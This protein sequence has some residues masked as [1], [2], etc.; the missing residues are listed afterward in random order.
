MDR[1]EQ[2]RVFVAVA[3]LRSFSR[4]AKQLER[5]PQAVTRAVAA[6]EQRL[7]TPL[8]HRTTRSVSLTSDGERYLEK[9]RRALAEMEALEAPPDDKELR[10]VLAVTAPVLFGQL[11]VAPIVRSFLAT[12]TGVTARLVLL[13]RVVSLAEE[14]IDVAVRIGALPDSALVARQV[15]R[16]RTVLVASPDYLERAGTPRS[17]EA[18]AKH[19]CIGF[20]GT[21]ATTD[22]WTF[23]KRSVSVRPR[24]VVNTAQAAI[25]AAVEGFG[26]TRVISYQVERLV[27]AGKLK[28]VLASTEPP[29][30][31]VQLVHLPGAQTRVASAFVE[32]AVAALTNRLR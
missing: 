14:G 8:L 26:V 4:A 1:L 10:G 27:E 24:L 18:L 31:P 11:H 2:W 23:G 28:I 25:D 32:L 15:A 16:V 5:S 12:H 17:F 3:G 22:R 29:P 21:G 19:A 13:D 7:G 30:V 9:S 20:T 6:L